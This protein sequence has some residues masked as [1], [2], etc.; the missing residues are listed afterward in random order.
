MSIVFMLPVM[1]NAQKKIP[2]KFSFLN[3]QINLPG[4][5]S[6]G[7]YYGYGFSTGTEFKYLSKKRTELSQSADFSLFTHSSYGTSFLLSS[8]L[9]F[10]LKINKLNFDFKLGPGYMLFNNYSPTY[11]LVDGRYIK[12]SKL[13]NMI[14][15]LGSFSISYQINRFKP[16]ISYGLMVESPF[17]QNSSKILPRQLA[18]LGLYFNINRQS[19][20][21]KN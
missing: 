17:I 18:E 8:M 4:L 14:A 6:Y 15:F 11:R 1:V 20:Q 12:D 19:K 2:L 3:Q 5:K 13:Q 21:S 10:R 9:D 7:N 16:F